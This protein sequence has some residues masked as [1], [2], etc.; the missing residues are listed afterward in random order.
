MN[1]KYLICSYHLLCNF[2]FSGEFKLEICQN[3]STVKNFKLLLK[4]AL[5]K[6]LVYKNA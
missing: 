1:I 5:L 3:V 2:V 4:F 6:R